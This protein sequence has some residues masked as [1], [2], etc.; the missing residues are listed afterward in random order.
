[1]GGESKLRQ[2]VTNGD[3]NIPEV[4]SAF[5]LPF[6]I[7]ADDA[8]PLM[9]NIMKPYPGSNLSKECL[10]FNY[11][12]SRARRVSENAFGILVARFKNLVSS[13]YKVNS[14]NPPNKNGNCH[15]FPKTKVAAVAEWYRYRTVACFVTGSSPVPLKTRRVGQRCTLN[16]SR[17]ETSS[18]RWCGV[19]VREGVPDQVSS[20]STMVQTWS[21]AKSPRVAEQCD[22]KIQSINQSPKQKLYLKDELFTLHTYKV[23]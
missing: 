14:S 21:V 20:T 5:K 16:L 19:V 15:P 23:E 17:A 10:V 2:A 3:L 6:V 1:M 22:V 12:L 8:F 13:H 9:P 4:G 18:S 7:L 11:R